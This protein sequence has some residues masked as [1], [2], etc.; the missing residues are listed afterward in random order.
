VFC[1]QDHKTR[2][3][4]KVVSLE[5]W[6]REI[7]K[8]YKAGYRNIN[9][10]GGEPFLHKEIIKYILFAKKVWFVII[11]AHTNAVKLSHLEFAEKCVRAW[12][13]SI[14][15]SL[16]HT[17]SE[18]NDAIVRRKWWTEEALNAIKVMQNLWVHIIVHIVL[19][20]LNY[21]EIGKITEDFFRMKI[22]NIIIM[23]PTIQW[24]MDELAETMMI[25]YSD[26]IPYI[27]ETLSL[28]DGT[29]GQYISLFN[30]P[31]CL[32]PWYEQYVMTGTNGVLQ[33]LDDTVIQYFEQKQNSNAYTKECEKCQ[34]KKLC[35]WI[36][37][38]YLERYGNESFE[39]FKKKNI[40]TNI[41]KK[42]SNAVKIMREDL[43]KN[44]IT[45]YLS[46]LRIFL[47]KSYVFGL[48]IPELW[49]SSK[50]SEDAVY[51]AI[52]DLYSGTKPRNDMFLLSH[53]IEALPE[54]HHIEFTI[55]SWDENSYKY[56]F[57]FQGNMGYEIMNY[58]FCS[59]HTSY[60][61][62]KKI[63]QIFRIFEERNNLF[64]IWVDPL[65]KRMKLY[66]WL[67]EETREEA[68]ILIQSVSH[69]LWYTPSY[70]NESQINK[71]DCIGIDITDT[72]MELKIYELSSEISNPPVILTHN[73]PIKEMGYMKSKSG[74]KKKFFRLEKSIDLSI[75]WDIFS[76][77]WILEW[78][79]KDSN[80]TIIVKEKVKY[81]CEEWEKKEIY[82]I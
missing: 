5:E 39:T 30:I 18:K 61:R 58:I 59:F 7:Y 71:Y 33:E 9:F 4:K 51:D 27:R 23:F 50:R 44:E 25:E 17:D 15:I 69:V 64:H 79:R 75:F 52:Y 73:S 48:A 57:W 38:P 76:Y 20:R 40:T 60:E 70:T 36:D 63:V 24:S 29:S 19:N 22:T 43:S 14:S 32:V 2:G 12:L 11:S 77:K 54:Y 72:S 35:P 55:H 65:W 80:N 21:T 10:T 66:I 82:F 68:E 81:Y 34:Y 46:L 45:T 3:E 41:V 28:M 49:Y 1:F 37:I 62:I 74:R 6:M 56:I 13:N 26:V 47:S 67:Y 8:A 31:A 16:H 53:T 78:I 42:S